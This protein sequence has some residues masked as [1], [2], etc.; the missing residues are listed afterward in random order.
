MPCIGVQRCSV[1]SPDPEQRHL[2]ARLGTWNSYSPHLV[3]CST[4]RDDVW[5]TSVSVTGGEVVVRA[6]GSA[7]RTRRA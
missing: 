4:I 5:G 3:C 2:G 1:S 7:G 6:M